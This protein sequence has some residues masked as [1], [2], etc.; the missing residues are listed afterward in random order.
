MQRKKTKGNGSS[1]LP[2]IGR[3]PKKE[4]QRERIL[5]EAAKVIAIVGYDRCSLNQIA[6]NLGLTAPALYTYF[7]DKQA[8]F[9]EIV[10]SL[11]LGMYDSVKKSVEPSDS[12][13]RQLE[14]LMI[15]HADYFETHYWRFVAGSNGYGGVSRAHL[16]SLTEIEGYREKYQKLL[17]G[18]LRAG[19]KQ[20][21][22]VKVDVKTTVLAIYSMLN[23]VRWY[24]P[25]GPKRPRHYAKAFFKLICEG[26]CR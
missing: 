4:N 1:A 17:S 10:V 6:N 9:D 14:S 21:Q 26:L 5:L 16:T 22:F 15:A 11:T 25:D 24:R 7:K 19:I 2:R 18:I 8:I 3:P 13:I 12:P 23:M 20:K